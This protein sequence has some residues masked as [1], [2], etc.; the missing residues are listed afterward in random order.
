MK[1]PFCNPAYGPCN[2]DNQGN[3]RYNLRK[4]KYKWKEGETADGENPSTKRVV[5]WVKERLEK[6]N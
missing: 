1:F 4:N 3:K 2:E 6:K 5:D